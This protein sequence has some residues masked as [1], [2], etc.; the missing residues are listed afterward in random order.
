MAKS[1]NL[2]LHNMVL[3]YLKH[4]EIRRNNFTML[5][6]QWFM[7]VQDYSCPKIVLLKEKV[8][9]LLGLQFND[10]IFKKW[11]PTDQPTNQPTHKAGSRDAIASKKWLN[12]KSE[13]LI[14]M[15]HRPTHYS[16]LVQRQ[17]QKV[18]R[19]IFNVSCPMS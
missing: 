13:V 16:M 5:W 6:N 9:L 11:P 12:L 14:L 17:Y 19:K 18:H 3:G 1:L 15:H 8:L 7:N 10:G 4:S 2:V